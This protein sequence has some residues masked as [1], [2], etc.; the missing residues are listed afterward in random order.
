M[1]RNQEEKQKRKEKT[2]KKTLA[3]NWRFVAHTHYLEIGAPLR[4]F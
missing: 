1:H 2:M 4:L 3:P